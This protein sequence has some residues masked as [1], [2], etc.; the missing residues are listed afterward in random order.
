M[1]T[2]LKLVRFWRRILLA[3]GL[4]LLLLILVL[5]VVAFRWYRETPDI[6]QLE[7]LRLTGST[8]I[9]AAD[10][11]PLAT[12]AAVSGSNYTYR[13]VVKLNQVSPA[14]ISAVIFSE[15][16]NFYHDYGI[17]PLGIVRAALHDIT[18]LGHGLQG[19]S[20]ISSQLVKQTLLAKIAETRSFKYKFQSIVLAIELNRLF[21]KNEILQMYLNVIPWGGNATGIAAAAQAYFNTTPARLNLA[22]SLY[23]ARLIPAPNYFYYHLR[24]VRADMKILLDK[25]VQQGWIT[26]SEA[27]S[28]WDYPLV[29]NGWEA[30][31]GPQGQLLFAKLVNPNAR[32][33]PPLRNIAPRFVFAVEQELLRRFGVAR[34]FGEGGLKVY[35]TL[36]LP[37]QEAAEEAARQ[38]VHEVTPGAQLAI[39]ALDP[40]TGAVRAMVGALPGTPGQFNRATQA[41][42][43]PGSA[44]KPFVYGTALENGW[45]EASLVAD[46]P[47]AIPDPASPGGYYRPHNYTHTFMMRD[48]TIRYAMD[49]SLN[50]PAIRTAMKVGLD[51]IAETF[52]RA[53]FKVPNPPVPPIAIGAVEVTPME[54]A[55]DYAA[56][57]NGGY[58]MR[59]YLI[60]RVTTASGKLL[61]QAEPHPVRLFSPQVAYQ[62]WSMLQ[63][64]VYDLGDHS[65]A[66]WAKIPGIIMGAKTGTSPQARDLWFCG[67]TPGLVA[68]VWTGNDNYTPMR[69]ANGGIPS[70]S[71]IP[72]VIW[73]QFMERAIVGLQAAPP[74]VPPGLVPARINLLTG[75]LSPHGALAYFPVGQVPQAPQQ[76]SG[77]LKYLPFDLRTGCPATA[78]TPP[79]AIIW[80]PAGSLPASCASGSSTSVPL[81]GSS[82]SVPTSPPSAPSSP[83]PAPSAPASPAPKTSSPAPSTSPSTTSGSA[84]PSGST[85]PAPAS[86]GSSVPASGS[87]SPSQLATPPAG[88]AQPAGSSGSASPSST[89]P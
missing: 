49:N 62:V 55:G 1:C 21:T 19:A 42:R 31:Y 25:M 70:S 2:R 9:Y 37:M 50:I 51:K 44:V 68:V 77:S 87:T 80:R 58:R 22:Q 36:S 69:Y 12:L 67:I 40:Y 89:A 52:K 16:R 88:S 38:A 33:I 48:I 23:L 3:F 72:A 18:H 73:R 53:D 59:P 27:Q 84:S 10:G 85:S 30:R 5:G 79:D 24:E 57:L 39:V 13:T 46:K 64:Y 20:T 28:A 78:S 29:P 60:E 47:L 61:Y 35:T 17:N 4:L 26:P 15:D 76:V 66:Y 32:I 8:T 63:G 43:S 81:S 34:V 65:L 83:S 41:W 86:A 45:T 56:F 6:H 7:T 54:M 82:Q 14:L 74:P 71:V 75:Q 11:T